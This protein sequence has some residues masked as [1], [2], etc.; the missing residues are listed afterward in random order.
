MACGM[1]FNI[2][3]FSEYCLTSLGELSFQGELVV[4]IIAG[5]GRGSA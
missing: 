2:M 3:K 1:S 4:K 5:S